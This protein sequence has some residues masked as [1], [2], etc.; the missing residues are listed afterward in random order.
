MEA[1]PK[2]IMELIPRSQ[3]VFLGCVNQ[4]AGKEVRQVCSVGC[5]GCALCTKPKITPSEKLVMKDNM[6]EIPSD[7]ED[8]ETAVAKCPTK[9]FVVRIP[10]EEKEEAPVADEA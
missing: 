2:G 7:W 9:S 10:V 8:F 1:C 4:D 5:I 6:P 3:K